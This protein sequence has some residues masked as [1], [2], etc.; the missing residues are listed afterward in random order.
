MKLRLGIVAALAFLLVFS[1]QIAYLLT[2]WR[3]FGSVGYTDIFA[4]II[5]TRLALFFAAALIF[6]ALSLLNISRIADRPKYLIWI[7]LL[8]SIIFG[9][10]MQFGWET[11]L[12]ALNYQSFH[13][14]DPLFQK[15]VGFYV[16]TLPFIRFVWGAIFVTVLINLIITMGVYLVDQMDANLLRDEPKEFAEM[17]PGKVIAH[18][19]ALV[20]V[21]FLLL[22][23]HYFL[24]RFDLLYST[25]GVV[26]GAGYTDIHAQLPVLNLCVGVALLMAIVLFAFAAGW[27]SRQA[28]FLVGILLLATAA[29]GAVYPAAIQQ[30]KVAP[31]EITMEEPFLVHNIGYT[32]RAY[33]LEDVDE[34][35][36]PVSYNLTRDDLL[37]N[38][39]TIDN[40]RLWD[41]RP[42]LKTYKQLQEIRLYYEFFD[43]DVDRYTIDGKKR[44][45]MLSPRELS[46]QQLPDQAKTWLNQHLVYT[47]GY[48]IC[49]SP[50]NEV[51]P[52]G[53]P[54]FYIKNLPPESSIGN[55]T[56]PEIYYGEGQ[57]DYVVVDTDLEEFDYPLGDENVYTTYNGTG[58]VNLDTST[59]LLMS[60]RMGSLKILI[61]DYIN[62][63]SRILI[64]RN[65]LERVNN[66]APFL[67][68][69]DDPYMVFAEGQLYW[70]IDAYTITNRYPYSEPVGNFNYIRNP[71]K[72]TVD[73]YNGS[74]RYYVVDEDPLL[75]AYISIFPD[76]FLPVEAMPAELLAHIRYPVDLFRIQADVY[77][78]YHMTEPQVFYNREDTWDIPKEIYQENVLQPVEPYYVIM[79]LPEAES[80]SEEF[81]L[82]QPF[83]PRSKNNMIAWM[84]A[85]SDMP[86]YGR[87]MVF[88]FPKD[89]LIFG[90]LQVE[91]KIDQ[92]TKISE[93]LTLW[94]QK[95][96]RV[97]RGNTL[98]IPIENSLLYI[99][100][101]YLQAE[102]SEFPELKR[103]IVV[104]GD[105]V[106]MDDR[107]EGALAQIF[108]EVPAEKTEQEREKA[109]LETGELIERAVAHY[110]KAQDYLRTGNWSGY[111]KEIEELGQTLGVLEGRSRA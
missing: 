46:Q 23:V 88:K 53:L 78:D 3:W 17:I 48:G 79:K 83:T 65:V 93:Q 90:P 60:Y 98:V 68:Y 76:L 85:K 108:G 109:E 102:N 100:P 2:E 64:H 74:V 50:A 104:Y 35:A 38:N 28:L 12:L 42:L 57:K 87:L 14:Q 61:T 62:D 92:D 18:I 41:W 45:V 77:R 20:G 43:V 37:A 66:I 1:G 5:E 110:E 107:L 91:A 29:F 95:G 106:I 56:R 72:V 25:T 103:V 30:Y 51:S 70:V 58:G 36:F 26:Y 15:D 111:G 16:F 55:I 80:E 99:E 81:I 94:S 4:T 13:L 22:S 71:V 52:G 84:C 54:E 11:L 32:L 44:L 27:K 6:G 82:I 47:H 39:A 69:D 63:Q 31:N 75:K 10:V 24:E 59:Q 67:A 7:V 33:D 34:I 40:I 19:S 73:A 21:L 97:I 96:S 49:M 8:L 86:E 89:Q 105:Q 9:L 101:L